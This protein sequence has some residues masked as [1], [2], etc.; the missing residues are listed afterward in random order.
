MG[1]ALHLACDK[2]SARPLIGKETPSFPSVW[3]SLHCAVLFPWPDCQLIHRCH[4][5]NSGPFRYTAIELIGSWRRGCIFRPHWAELSVR[6]L[7]ES[8]SGKRVAR[9]GR[10]SPQPKV[11]FR[12][13]R[14]SQ[15]S[16]NGEV[17]KEKQGRGDPCYFCFS[18]GAPVPG[19]VL[20]VDSIF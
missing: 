20:Y 14:C 1:Q 15:Q 6:S 2:E 18:C 8:L 3:S 11:S 16:A 5:L 9:K 17:W 19:G 7:I 10:P 4:T 13:K 12:P